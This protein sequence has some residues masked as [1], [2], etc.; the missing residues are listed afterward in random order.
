MKRINK[1]VL[2]LAVI[3]SV[4]VSSCQKEPRIGGTVSQKLAGEWWVQLYNAD[5]S[6]IYVGYTRWGTYNTADENV[7]KLWVS[8][9]EHLF[10]PGLKIKI[11]ANLKDLSFGSQTPVTNAYEG[12]TDFILSDGKIIL[13]GTKSTGGLV[14][15]SIYFKLVDV[16]DS[17][18][19]YVL[20][21]YR[22]TGWPE[23]N[24]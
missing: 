19:E 12:G 16:A 1:Y 4:H 13:K 21:G 22:H 24:H 5:M 14:T 3:L 8:D 7:D 2:L 23:D 10:D 17:N 15:D 11:D 6:E 20:A 9:Y 18:A